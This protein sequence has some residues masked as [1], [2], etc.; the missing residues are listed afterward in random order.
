MSSPAQ[1]PPPI[2]PDLT[3]EIRDLARGIRFLSC[4]FALILC[5]F[6]A[7]LAFKFD[8]FNMIFADMLGGK[9]L[10]LPAAIL[11]ENGTFFITLAL[12]LPM[13]AVLS[14]CLLRNHC[15]AFVVV[16][17]IL[18]VAFLQ[19]QFTWSALSS[20]FMKI[21]TSTGAQ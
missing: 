1:S 7:Y 2:P 11:S 6:N 4:A 12:A 9:A 10:P 14:V 17:G 21:I 18:V 20:A 3:T 13:G 5:F 19:M 8:R 16:G 15:R